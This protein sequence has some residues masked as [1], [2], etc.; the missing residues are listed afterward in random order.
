MF[1][2]QKFIIETK[3]LVILGNI[4]PTHMYNLLYMI[5]AEMLIKFSMKL[6]KIIVEIPNKNVHPLIIIIPTHSFSH[7]KQTNF[8]VY[9]AGG[10][11]G[12]IFIFIFY[13]SMTI[14]ISPKDSHLN[15]FL[16]L[17]FQV[18]KEEMEK[19]FTSD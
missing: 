12:T 17:F 13:I 11:C 6:Q 14:S 3:S 5:P 19:Q 8:I 9:I 18:Q 4:H 15:I 10:K 2:T 16:L 7:H 1:C